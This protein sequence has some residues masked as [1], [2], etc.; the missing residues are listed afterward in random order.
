[1]EVRLKIKIF[2]HEICVNALLAT[3]SFM[4]RK[5]RRNEVNNDSEK[6]QGTCAVWTAYRI[7]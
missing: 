6:Y 5:Q 1:M 7:D 2:N 4:R 3:N